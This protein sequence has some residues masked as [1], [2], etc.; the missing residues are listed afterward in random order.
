MQR[1]ILFGVCLLMLCPMVFAGTRGA[2][3]NKVNPPE[4]QG[5]VTGEVMSVSPSVYVIGPG[6][7]LGFTVSDYATNG[8]ACHN[9]INFG[10]GSLSLG[11]M[12]AV[13]SD[14]TD[15]GTYYSYSADTG[16]TWTPLTWVEGTRQGWG[17]IDQFADAGGAEVTVAHAGIQVCIDAAKGANVW[18][19]APTGIATDLW[20]RLAVSSPISI[21]MVHANANPATDIWYTRSQDAGATW[22]IL[23]APLFTA[24]PSFLPDADAQDIAASGTNVAIVHAPDPNDGTGFSGGADVLLAL[25]GDNGTTWSTQVLL[26]NPGPGELTNGSE[27]YTPDGSVA[28]V[29]DSQGDL[30]IVWTNFLAVGDVSNNPGLFY[31]IDAPL[32]YWSEATGIIEIATTVHDTSIAKPTNLFGNLV[33]QPDIGIDANDNPYIIYQ[34]QISEQDTAEVFLQHIYA[35]GS[36]DGG[37]TWREPIDITPGTGFDASYGSMADRVDDNIHLTY[38]SDPLGGNAIR[39]NHAFI[40]V[41]VMYHKFDAVTLTTGIREVPGTTPETFRLE[42]NYPN[43]FNPV[44]NIRYS[45]PTGSDISLKVYD[46]LGQEVALLYSGFQEAGNYVADFDGTNFA[47]G[48]YYYTLTAGD[49]TETKKMLL[50]K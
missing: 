27:K 49:F 7:S 13:T 26:D 38:F 40:N 28:C 23:D 29:Y 22:D 44:T 20:P 41:A 37:F 5:A 32:S 39:G 11:R 6:D 48:T 30:H 4:A 33:T 17:N 9:L 21:H 8:S 1:M 3:V 25:S 36:P 12:M 24:G 10:D 43:P 2:R 18:S 46:V 42:Q 15:R 16:N 31:Q 14:A 19:C 35:T 47:N 50:V 45:L 34:Q